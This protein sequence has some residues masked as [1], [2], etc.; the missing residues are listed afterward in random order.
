MRNVTAVHPQPSFLSI[1]DHNIVTAH[2]K[3][4]GRFARKRPVTNDLHLRQEVATV[5]RDHLR[6]VPPSGGS[7]DVETAFVIVILQTAEVVAPPRERRLP[8]R[9]WRGDPQAEEK[10]NVAMTAR[11]AAWK[12]QKAEHETQDSP[13]KRAVRRAKTHVERVCDAACTRFL[14]KR[15]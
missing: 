6:A 4:L 1:W 10:L 7:V 2:V 5:I 3:W 11:R 13:L 8:G 12:R 15:V 14:G 9:G